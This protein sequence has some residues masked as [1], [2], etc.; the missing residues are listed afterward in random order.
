[1]MMMLMTMMILFARIIMVII[2]LAGA[3]QND[4]LSRT[5]MIMIILISMT[6]MVII[7]KFGR[8]N[9]ALKGLSGGSKVVLNQ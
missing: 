7:L 3:D 9:R 6:L 5:L 1:M 4:P 8:N 2:R